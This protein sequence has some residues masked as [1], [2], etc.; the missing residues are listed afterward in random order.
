[1]A[2]TALTG[3]F[4]LNTGTRHRWYHSSASDDEDEL[5]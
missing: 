4:R 2:E 1:M 5:P 3:A